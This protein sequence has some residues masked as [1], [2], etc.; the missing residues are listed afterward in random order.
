MC[1]FLL[2]FKQTILSRYPLHSL[3]ECW[4]LG[5]LRSLIELVSSS[6]GFCYFRRTSKTLS[7]G[8]LVE[9]VWHWQ[10][11]GV[12]TDTSWISAW[13]T[14]VSPLLLT[15][16]VP[17]LS[18]PRMKGFTS[19]WT[20]SVLFKEKN[21][22]HRPP[23]GLAESSLGQGLPL[24][25]PLWHSWVVHLR[26]TSMLEV[27]HFPSASAHRRLLRIGSWNVSPQMPV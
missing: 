27:F 12:A 13:L 23:N 21:P 4:V 7:K 17:P 26:N 1:L 10:L 5:C 14:V 20:C 9:L 16:I 24:D 6:K 8:V 19:W 11:S 25:L 18:N 15:S 22:S 3:A 2:H